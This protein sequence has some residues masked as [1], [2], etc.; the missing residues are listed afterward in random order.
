MSSHPLVS[1]I[2]PV[3]NASGTINKCLRSLL[4]QTM[5]NIEIILVDDG[6]TD[7]SGS[8][9]NRYA[10]SD[11]RIVCIHKPNGGTASARQAGIEKASG[12]Y[13]IHADPDDWVEKNMLEELYSKAVEEKA[14][15]V[16]CDYFVNY[17]SKSRYISQKPSSYRPEEIVDELFHR[18]HGS[19]WNKMIKTSC[20]RNNSITFQKGVNY[21]EDKLFNIK[22]LMDGVNKVSYIHRAY[23]H[24]VQNS[25]S[26]TGNEN[27]KWLSLFNAYQQEVT[28]L[29]RQYKKDYLVEQVKADKLTGMI[30][31]PAISEEQFKEALRERVNWKNVT[32]SK[33]MRLLIK[34]AEISSLKLA[35]KL[36][37]ILE[38]LPH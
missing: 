11:S 32:I 1:V 28:E 16:I 8:I 10:R 34:I 22:L 25:G 3:F 38:R 14:D 7:D 36:Y 18:L 27:P 33:P 12:V 31:H 5:R 29:L 6:S 17:S 9:C 15:M 26:Y 4:G 35:Q 37:R 23:Y 30:K 20:Y 19:L 2:V 21:C 13:M 24:Y